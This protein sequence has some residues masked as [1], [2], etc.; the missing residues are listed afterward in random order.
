MAMM[1]PDDTVPAT[2]AS[3]D[4]HYL[5]D[6]RPVFA[7]ANCSM[8]VAL[9]DE[10]CSRGFT[11]VTGKAYLLN[12]TINTNLG[13]QDERKLM[14]GKHT[15]ADIYCAKCN[16]VLGWKYIV[17]PTGDQKYKE[18]RYILE[19]SKIVKENNW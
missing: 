3:Q 9:Q 11:A 15:C 7:C 1:Y 13:Q 17:A 18:S 6:D 14:T 2:I 5:P 19:K 12:S 4:L 10:L 16:A 8:V